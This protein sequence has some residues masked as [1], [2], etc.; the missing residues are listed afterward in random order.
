[1]TNNEGSHEE[2]ALDFLEPGKKY[3]AEI[4]TDGGR[5]NQDCD[6]RGD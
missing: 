3:I 2:I 5:E 1:M 6:T 4:Y